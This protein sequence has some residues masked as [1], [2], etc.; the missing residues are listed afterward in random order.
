[1]N[2]LVCLV[3]AVGILLIIQARSGMR[4]VA[5]PKISRSQKENI[6]WPDVVDNLASAIRSGL[7]LGQAMLV[8]AESA[9]QELSRPLSVFAQTYRSSGDFKL[10]MLN[11]SEQLKSPAAD[12][13]A[14]ALI[15]AN[16]LGGTELGTLLRSLSD[17]LRT[18][19]AL[20]GEIRARQ[21][22][23]VNGAKL[24]IAAPWLTVAV[25]SLHSD[26]RQMYF[27]P[28]GLWLLQ[29]CALVSVVAYW[30]MRRIGKLP[31]NSRIL[32][33]P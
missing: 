26:A 21:S 17:S 12:T 5:W 10:A 20:T 11:L 23:T 4:Q 15:M 3:G 16:D 19:A 27:S 8:L 33:Q 18:Q 28:G 7:S 1:M 24:A 25:L 13:F 30:L 9:P 32:G 2:L 6:D 31:N 14:A 22:W 29:V